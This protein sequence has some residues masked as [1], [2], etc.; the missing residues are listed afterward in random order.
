M[1]TREVHRSPLRRVMCPAQNHFSFLTL[2]IM[3]MPFVLSLTHMLVLLFLYAMLSTILSILVCAA[4]SL[5]RVCLV[6]LHASAPC[7]IASSTQKLY[8]CPFR[9]ITKLFLF[10]FSAYA[11]QP[12]IGY[13]LYL[14]VLVRFLEA[15]VLLEGYVAFNIFCHYIVHVDGGVCC[16]QPS[17]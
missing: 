10:L 4:A 16:L 13:S 17:P 2:F 14:V 6:S 11:A 8:T 12:A 5:F 7:A 3:S 1:V 9:Q 15:V